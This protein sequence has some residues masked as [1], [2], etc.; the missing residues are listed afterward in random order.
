MQEFILMFLDNMCATVNDNKI[1]LEMPHPLSLDRQVFTKQ[2]DN[3]FYNR[4]LDEPMKIDYKYEV[5]FK[6]VKEKF[7]AVNKDLFIYLPR[8]LAVDMKLNGNEKE[9]YEEGSPASN[10]LIAFDKF[11]IEYDN[12]LLLEFVKT[13]N[14][15][16][17]EYEYK[18]SEVHHENIKLIRYLIYVL[19]HC[20]EITLYNCWKYGIHLNPNYNISAE[21]TIGFNF[22]DDNIVYR[23]G[24]TMCSST[25]IEMKDDYIHYKLIFCPKTEDSYNVLISEL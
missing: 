9:F 1:V 13:L 22:Y 24:D 4:Y 18:D 10:L 6:Q 7:E 11:Q 16:I 2:N 5:P 12:K 19:S 8:F 23:V 25:T 20:K 14:S 21:N 15:Y 3:L 17:K